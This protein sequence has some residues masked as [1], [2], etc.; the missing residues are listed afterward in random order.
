[1]GIDAVGSGAGAWVGIAGELLD[2]AMLKSVVFTMGWKEEVQADL[3]QAQTHK[4]Q[5]QI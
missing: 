2:R 3:E 5:H 4:H 1:M